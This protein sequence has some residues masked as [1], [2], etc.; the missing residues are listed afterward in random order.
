MNQKWHLYQQKT[1][2]INGKSIQ[3][4]KSK[5]IASKDISKECGENQIFHINYLGREHLVLKTN[6]IL[7]EAE[8]NFN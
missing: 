4:K 8:L 1:P 5:S 7:E 2:R 3:A 6:K